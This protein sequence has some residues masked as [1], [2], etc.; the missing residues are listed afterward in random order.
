MDTNKLRDLLNQLQNEIQTAETL[1]DQ[2]YQM[3]KDLD[4]NIQALLDRADS[5]S[6]D[7]ITGRLEDAI[8]HFEVTHPTLTVVISKV[9]DS[10]SG[11]GI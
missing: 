2:G 4:E 10:L 11:A 1:D 9:L 6:D 7:T 3:L 8:Y 5:H